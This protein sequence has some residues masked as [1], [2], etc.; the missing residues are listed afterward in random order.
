MEREI[1]REESGNYMKVKVKTAETRGEKLFSYQEVPGFLPLEVRRIN[2]QKEYCYPISGKVALKQ[3]LTETDFHLTDV[4][5]L[6]TALFNMA[7]VLE[8]Y[9]LDSRGLMI[10]EDMIF[11]DRS[12]QKIYGIYCGDNQ[13][14]FVAA[15]GELLEFI[16]EKMNQKEKELVFFVYGMH[17]QT[18][19]ENCSRQVLEQYVGGVEKQPEISCIPEKKDKQVREII[20]PTG[21]ENPIPVNRVKILSGGI[22]GIG[23]LCPLVLWGAGVFRSEV[24]QGVDY[25]RLAGAVLFFLGVSGYGAWRLMTIGQ[26]KTIYGLVAGAEENRKVCLIPQAKGGEPIPVTE[27]PFRLGSDKRRSDFTIQSADISPMHAE[28]RQ[29]GGS[30]MLVDEE[31]VYGTYKNEHQLVPWQPVLLQDGDVIRLARWEY[32]VE[33]TPYHCRT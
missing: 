24:S 2:G 25:G 6:F 31:S 13:K 11:V 27:F 15:I 21:R 10:H 4:K 28:I 5:A 33:I 18:K 12:E 29:E 1:I 26:K 30:V 22:L 3:Y 17:K 19:E 8:E 9:L 16:M 7:E 14:E 32:V 23:V 20:S